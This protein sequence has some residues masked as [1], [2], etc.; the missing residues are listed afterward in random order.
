MTKTMWCC[1]D[2]ASNTSVRL[3]SRRQNLTCLS[4]DLS[5]E[6]MKKDIE[7]R[8]ILITSKVLFTYE[9]G[10]NLDHKN[11]MFPGTGA[12][13]QFPCWNLTCTMSLQLR[14]LEVSITE[15][16]RHCSRRWLWWQR[17]M[18]KRGFHLLSIG[19]ASAVKFSLCE[20][21]LSKKSAV[22]GF[23]GRLETRRYQKE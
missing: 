6:N 3:S 11:I 21:N 10:K 1:L 14:A 23:I 8:I 12:I 13:E 19:V 7:L 22:E 9:K 18:K 20:T 5:V 4:S 2:I 16:L 15:N 17:F